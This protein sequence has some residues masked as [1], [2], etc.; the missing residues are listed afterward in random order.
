MGGD[1]TRLRFRPDRNG[2]S[3][4]LQQGKVML[5]ADWNELAEIFDRRWRS[6]TMDVIGKCAASSYT[7]PHAFQIE[8]VLNVDMITIGTGRLYVDGLVAENHGDPNASDRQF[9]PTMAELVSATATTFDKQPYWWTTHDLPADRATQNYLVYADV[10]EREV[11]A[12]QDPDLIDE[13]V[14]VE[15]A[16]RVDTVWRVRALADIGNQVNHDTPPV[17]FAGWSDITRPSAGRLSTK[18]TGVTQPADDCALPLQSGYRGLENRLYRIEIHNGS[19]AP[20]GPTFKW[21]KDNGSLAVRVKSIDGSGKKLTLDMIGRDAVRR[22]Q[23]GDFVE[24]TDDEHELDGVPGTLT[25]VS[26]QPD[27]IE[28]SITVADTVSAFATGTNIRVRRWETGAGA[29]LPAM[30]PGTVDLG[31]G[32][33]ITFALDPTVAGGGFKSGDYWTFWARTA[34]GHIE[35]LNTAPPRGIHHHYCMLAIVPGT[36]TPIDLRTLWPPDACASCECSFYI[37]A[38]QHNSG[39]MTIQD[40]LDKVKDV[41]G[42]ICLGPG[43]FNLDQM[44]DL[45]GAKSIHLQGRGWKT[46]LAFKPLGDGNPAVLISQGSDV[47]LEDF[48]LVAFG[49]FA[50][51]G[52]ALVITNSIEVTV[53]RCGVFCVQSAQILK[54]PNDLGGILADPLVRIQEALDNATGEAIT[55]QGALASLR[56]REC[57]VVGASAIGNS[58]VWQRAA[59]MSAGASPD[60][61]PLAGSGGSSVMTVGLQIEDNLVLAG[62]HGGIQLQGLVVQL[63]PTRV[64]RNVV[65]GLGQG[66]SLIGVFD[67]GFGLHALTIE[68][69]FVGVFGDGIAIGAGPALVQGNYIAPPD[70]TKAGA[71]TGQTSADYYSSLNIGNVQA[72][73]TGCG[74]VIDSSPLLMSPMSPGCQIIDNQIVGMRGSGIAIRTRVLTT[75]IRGN[76]IGGVGLSGIVMEDTSSADVLGIEG[77]QL[78]AIGT[79]FSFAGRSIAGIGVQNVTQLRVCDNTIKGVGVVTNGQA[80]RWTGIGV[81]GSNG[82]RIT[83]NEVFDVGPPGQFVGLGRGILVATSNG[84]IDVN[85]NVVVRNQDSIANITEFLD[86]QSDWLPLEINS[87]L[88]AFSNPKTIVWRRLSA[89]VGGRT[90]PAVSPAS[91]VDTSLPPQPTEVAPAP[92]SPAPVIDTGVNVISSAPI[93]DSAL[94]SNWTITGADFA[95]LLIDL[96]AISLRVGPERARVRSNLFDSYGGTGIALV[97]NGDTSVFSDNQCIWS[98]PYTGIVGIRLPAFVTIRA[99]SLIASANFI[100]ADGNF[101]PIV[102]SMSLDVPDLHYAVF[103]NMTV[104]IIVRQGAAL[105]PKWIN[106]EDLW[107]K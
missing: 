66:I 25:T 11:T 105:D 43:T 95:H 6:E 29:L 48:L 12:L 46:V 60:V 93:V 49:V 86:S 30:P 41:G 16:T 28:P 76:L 42:R 3:V 51:I 88:A 107:M 18:F 59:L 24:V 81:V 67:Y 47:T 104:S 10:W 37:T 53:H 73:G 22:F 92:P 85:D 32:V 62:I 102:F 15:T 23:P 83:G 20:G 2:S 87:V 94:R 13:G 63:G 39:N 84:V 101:G 54:L 14:G 89:D 50:E 38:D 27:D 31:D 21:S 36:G 4:L 100:T 26:G 65:V 77:N 19:D 68:N 99:P 61:S 17:Q 35:T 1:Y 5:D 40:A 97:D 58:I 9:D 90:A 74:I 106:E 71:G 64:A 96:S 55:L 80:L 56:I 44:L 8:R 79:N 70:F 98:T 45:T 103:G 75:Q 34:S 7:N 91:T 69:N 72:G 52:H 57:T 33:Q 82:V 78:L